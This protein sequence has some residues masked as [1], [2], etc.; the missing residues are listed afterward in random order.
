[1]PEF[2]IGQVLKMSVANRSHVTQ[3]YYV[4][5]VE[6][7]PNAEQGEVKMVTHIPGEHS[8]RMVVGSNWEYHQPRMTIVGD[9]KRFGY[10][11]INQKLK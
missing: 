11:L 5:V 1:M 9:K 10:L 8:C 2:K 4:E 7:Y 6:Y 3:P